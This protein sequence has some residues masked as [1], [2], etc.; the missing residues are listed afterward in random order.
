MIELGYSRYGASGYEFGAGVTTILALDHPESVIGIHLTTLESDLAPVVDDTELSD[1]ERSYLAII[2]RW[3]LT[4]R[5]YSAI[6]STKP[7]TIG[8]GLN[9]RRPGSQHISARSGTRGATLRPRTISYAPRLP[10][11]G[12]RRALP[13]RC[14]TY[15]T[16][17]GTRS[18]PV[19]SARP[20]HSVFSRNR[21]SP[22]AR[23]RDP[24]WSVFTT[25][26]AGPSFRTAAI[27]R[28][29]SNQ[30]QLQ[31]APERVLS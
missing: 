10:C 13:R 31:L 30:R 14:A 17:A 4:E 19:A 29:L 28:R 16:I 7:Q 3:E 25:S 6:Q 18:I 2:R 21:P 22:R 24:I 27:S 5:G 9:A 11:T 12:S 26:S 23:C 1:T 15:R 8:Y 20:P